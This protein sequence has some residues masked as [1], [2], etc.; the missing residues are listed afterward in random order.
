MATDVA[1]RHCGARFDAVVQPSGS[2]LHDFFSLFLGV[3]ALSLPVLSVWVGLT[4]PNGWGDLAA[5]G[6]V[7]ILFLPW[8]VG[9]I[10][11]LILTWLTQERR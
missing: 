2:C 4:W 8:I 10:S 7:L 6:V 1:C 5:Y 11:L 3:W 9:I